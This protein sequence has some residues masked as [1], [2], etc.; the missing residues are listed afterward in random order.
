VASERVHYI[1]P[2]HFMSYLL[3]QRGESHESR[4]A[5]Q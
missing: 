4:N 2:L 3:I 1:S 5:W